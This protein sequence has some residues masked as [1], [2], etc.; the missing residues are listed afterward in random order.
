VT[1]RG[2]IA[3]KVALVTSGVVALALILVGLQALRS[4][5]RAL[6]GAQL[7]QAT[8]RLITN[9]SIT[10]RILEERFPGSWRLAPP[11]G[12]PVTIQIYNGNGRDPAWRTSEPMPVILYKGDTPLI[13][14]PEV[15]ALLVEASRLTGTEF[16]L[17]QKLSS[18]TSQ[19]PQVAG[20]PEGRALRLVATAVRGDTASS[21]T[22]A[23]AT[24][25]PDLD[26]ATGGPAAA[27]LVFAGQGDI[28]GR[29]TAVESDNWTLYRALRD[30]ANAIV[31]V[32]YAG[33]PFAPFAER[34]AVASRQVAEGL[35]PIVALVALGAS[36]LLFLLVRG[37]LRP[38]RT[39]HRA[40]SRLAEGQWPDAIRVKSR[41]EVGALAHAFNRMADDLRQTY[42]TIEEKVHQRTRELEES[43]AKLEDARQVADEANRAKSR[44]L[45]N[46]SHEL[47]TPLNAII[48]Y[49]EMLEEEATE[50]GLDTLVPDLKKVHGAGRHLLQLINDVL[51]LSKIE[52]G[53]MDLYLETFDVR[54]MVDEVVN[55]IQPLV[56]QKG[57]TLV[58]DCPDDAGAM[59]ADLTKL[60]QSLFNL[61]S[62]A[63]KFTE[64][65]TV[66]LEVRREAGH[67]GP[68]LRF[69][70]RDSGIGMTEQQLERLFQPFSQAD[71][72]TTRRY[73]GTGLGLA[74]TKRFIEMM[75]GLVSVEST[76][77][78]GSTFTLRLP[79]STEEVVVRR[80]GEF[81]RQRGGGIVLLIDD[82]A[83]VHDL[84]GRIL[85]REGIPVV[86]VN[87]GDEGIS[88][89][90]EIHPSAIILDVM[91][92][93]ND[94]WHVLRELK[95]EP[96]L[97]G[98]P[99]LMLTIVDDRSFG[100]ALGASEYLT[101]PVDRDRLVEVVRRL[102]HESGSGTALVVDDDEAAR[103]RLTML[104]GQEGWSVIQAADG[105]QAL[106][107]LTDVEP[108]LILLDLQMPVLDGFGFLNELR[109]RP[110]G[111]EV[112]VV[113]IT[114]RDLT[115]DEREILSLSVRRVFDKLSLEE[116][117]LAKELR[118]VLTPG[119]GNG[120]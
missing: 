10:E 33:T 66:T 67:D 35:L 37:L 71:A 56:K 13:G 81:A 50:S 108:D 65:G 114:G 17:A 40:V 73:G 34:S 84:V 110:G 9:L 95:R 19:D 55:T 63:S 70:V 90:R 4:T 103:D 116:E 44:F 91:M 74:I 89:A 112:P 64:Q 104:L 69:S 100:M 102:R 12:G 31:G 62:N 57:N 20:G 43:N 119:G 26:P 25:M 5:D 83:T 7:D 2:S 79:A 82:D 16:A 105:Q 107:R 94:G 113:V 68:W 29:S 46:M 52:A 21:D 118:L 51:D 14:N 53:R 11:P 117:A 88:L 99:V 49:S 39:I 60:R 77:G 22:S 45:A 38:L 106:E 80:T 27:G 72:S 115:T 93:G 54:P 109:S 85:E 3:T 15:E 120:T 61:L 97:A 76:P 6:L 101:K 28:I 87:S 8:R 78:Q 18:R 41:D 42:A 24:V 96:K 92:P 59:H 32:V 36:L 75:G 48:G 23:V 111:L 47:R 30:S 58:V 1:T 98:I 86:A